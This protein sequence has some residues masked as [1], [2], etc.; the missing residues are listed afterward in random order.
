M[1]IWRLKAF[2]V[3]G[4][5]KH[6]SNTFVEFMILILFNRASFFRISLSVFR[7][8]HYKTISYETS[9]ILHGV[10]SQPT[11]TLTFS[12]VQSSRLW[13]HIPHNQFFRCRLTHLAYL[14]VVHGP[15][16]ARML[17]NLLSTVLLLLYG[18]NQN[19]MKDSSSQKRDLEK[20]EF[21]FVV[22]FCWTPR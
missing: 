2:F 3:R 19:E 10:S 9:S 11:H 22:M 20:K 15:P 14:T 17:L 7:E 21:V 18:G 13:R 6:T 4:T 1:V 12:H 5:A 16:Q 8:I